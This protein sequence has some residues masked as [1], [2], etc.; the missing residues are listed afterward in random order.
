MKRRLQVA[1]A[2]ACLVVVLYGSLQAKAQ[3]KPAA[4]GVRGVPN[5]AA[6]R[7]DIII[8]GKAFTA[9]IWPETVKKPV[10]Y[11]L[12]TAMGTLVTRGYPIE[13]RPGERTDHP[14]QVGLWF[15]Y[16]DVNGFDFWNNSAA[17]KPADRGHYGTIRHVRIKRTASGK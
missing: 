6:R 16:G 14:H 9:Y 10:L 5:E 15:N 2:F 13:P 3:S 17:I 11:P 8:D 4:G 12:R 7:V 1:G